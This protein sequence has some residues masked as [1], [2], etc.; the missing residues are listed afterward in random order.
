L[1]GILMS[2]HEGVKIES[3]D[4]AILASLPESAEP[5][6]L[7]DALFS[8]ARA[9]KTVAR[10]AEEEVGEGASIMRDNRMEL[11]GRWQEKAE[12]RL[13]KTLDAGFLQTTFLTVLG[14]ARTPKYGNV[15]E[16][17]F[18]RAD[19]M[20][21]SP[22]RCVEAFL[23]PDLK[24]LALAC[25][26][27]AELSP[28]RDRFHLSCRKAAAQLGLKDHHRAHSLLMALCGAEFLEVVAVGTAGVIRG[29]R[30][31]EYRLGPVAQ[32]EGARCGE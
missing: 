18:R 2:R 30:A 9:L 4:D 29:G 14:L 1:E 32:M 24:R 19:L 26:A 10:K 16:E 31:S 13:L 7:K 22:P 28:F 6:V 23:E 15:L 25:L 5:E 12:K 3:Y 20:L 11:I 17:A 8:F 21:A 27:L